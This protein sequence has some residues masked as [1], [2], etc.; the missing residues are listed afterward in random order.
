MLRGTQQWGFFSS[1]AGLVWVR[2]AAPAPKT[3]ASCHLVKPCGHSPRKSEPQCSGTEPSQ[4]SQG[5]GVGGVLESSSR[6]EVP[7]SQGLPRE[8]HIIKRPC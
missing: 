5:V 3:W 1:G 8:C 4:F 6:K 2:V 7:V